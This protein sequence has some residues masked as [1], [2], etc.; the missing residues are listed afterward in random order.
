M[1]NE[2]RNGSGVVGKSTVSGRVKSRHRVEGK[3]LS[4]REFARKLMKSGDKDATDWFAAKAGALSL[5]KSDKNK[6][7]AAACRAATKMSRSKLKK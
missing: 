3:N 1:T 4:L 6:Q 7:L 5:S 2:N